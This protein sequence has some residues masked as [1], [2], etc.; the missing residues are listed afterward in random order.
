MRY[1]VLFLLKQ[2]P[3]LYLK[4]TIFRLFTFSNVVVFFCLCLTLFFRNLSTFAFLFVCFGWLQPSFFNGK[5]NKAHEV[6]E[7]IGANEIRLN[8]M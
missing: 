3:H 7:M 1:N 2:F 6:E 5:K 4:G 8:N